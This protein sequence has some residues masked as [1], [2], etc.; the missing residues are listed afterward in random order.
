MKWFGQEKRMDTGE[1][2]TE[3]ERRSGSKYE[4][5]QKTR[6]KDRMREFMYGS[7]LFIVESEIC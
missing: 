3:S 1:R 5:K 4:G 2:L 6:W 7:S